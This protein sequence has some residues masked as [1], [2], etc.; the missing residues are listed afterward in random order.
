MRLECP[1][2]VH[3]KICWVSNNMMRRF[4]LWYRRWLEA[5]AA[6]FHDPL[7]WRFRLEKLLEAMGE[8][9]SVYPQATLHNC[10]SDNDANS[11]I[12]NKTVVGSFNPPD[13]NPIEN[14]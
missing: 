3:L 11:V 5:N 9:R 13:E 12:L 2:H 1:A 7:L 6:R 4:E 8:L 10:Q 14:E